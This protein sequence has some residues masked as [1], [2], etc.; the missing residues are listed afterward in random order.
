MP[1]T[2]AD[3]AYGH[4]GV[5]VGEQDSGADA[6]VSTTCRVCAVNTGEDRQSQLVQFRM[7]IKRRA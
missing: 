1:E 2:D 3:T 7:A 4:V 5:L 6:V